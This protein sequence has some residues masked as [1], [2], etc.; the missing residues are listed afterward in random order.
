MAHSFIKLNAQVTIGSNTPPQNYSILEVVSDSDHTGGL[1]LPQLSSADKAKID[2]SL[3]ADI[4]KSKGLFIYNTDTNNIEYWDGTQWVAARQVEPGWC[5]G[6][7]ILPPS[8]LK[9]SIRWGR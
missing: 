3:L 4:S 8:I 1:R 2:A 5:Q 7:L 6:L 9:T